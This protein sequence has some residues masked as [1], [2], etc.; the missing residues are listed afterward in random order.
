M[1]PISKADLQE[2]HLYAPLVAAIIVVVF[3]LVGAF[4][5]IYAFVNSRDTSIGYGFMSTAAAFWFNRPKGNKPPV[6]A[7][8]PP[9]ISSASNEQ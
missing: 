4:L 6:A 9:L 3:L 7:P 8:L 5:T 2:F 1:A